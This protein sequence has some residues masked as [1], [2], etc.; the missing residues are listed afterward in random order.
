[1]AM[2]I[3]TVS[4]YLKESLKSIRRN[5]VM[6]F[7]SVT[8]VA[9]ALFIFGIFMIIITNVNS[10]V[11]TVES[12]VEIKAFLK[13]DVTTLKAQ[14]IEKEI[15]EISGVKSV[16][17]ESK[18]EALKK[19][20]QELGQNKDLVE[21]LEEDNPFPAS[22]VIKVNKPS[23]VS[24]V[25][26]ELS[27]IE[28]FEKIND[29]QEVVNQ[30]IKITNFIK[31]LSLVL[32][33]ILGIIAVSLIS[34]TIKLTVYARKREIGIMKYI[35]ATDWFVRWPFIL[36]GIFLGLLGALIA[37]GLLA[38]GYSYGLNKITSNLLFFSF[39]PLNKIMDILFWKFSFVGMLIGG[40]G[41]LI[42]IRKFLVM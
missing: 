6:S 22:F 24:Y 36:E 35:G 1:M 2:K 3:R 17:F 20:S 18:E 29:A 42:S 4:Y 14:K 26:K 31:V 8:T 15:K 9:A 41:S 37:L 38:A 16:T 23:D 11:D 30:I 33:I 12:K 10:I 39:V 40:F 5:R 19:V 25:S 28:E 34:N 32:M 7:A 21:G 13:D 27:K